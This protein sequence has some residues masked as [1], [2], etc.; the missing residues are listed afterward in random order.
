MRQLLGLV[1]SLRNNL[2]R[3]KI[4]INAVAPGAVVTGMLPWAYAIPM[5]KAGVMVSDAGDVAKALLYSATAQETRRVET[6]GKEDPS[7]LNKPGRWN[8]RVILQLG[9]KYLEVEELLCDRRDAGSFIGLE[10][11][12]LVKASQALTDWRED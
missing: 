12:Q 8:G 11:L 2:T 4:T 10:Y 1:R 7:E 6:Y 3:D 5:L 9:D